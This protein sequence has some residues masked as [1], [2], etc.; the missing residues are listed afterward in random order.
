[1]H[2]TDRSFLRN[3]A[4]RQPDK[5]AARQA[6]HARYKQNPEPWFSWVFD[7]LDL[8]AGLRILEVGCGPADLWLH[9][10][11]RLP[12]GLSITLADLSHGM[13]AQSAAALPAE[14]GAARFSFLAADVQRLPFPDAH[15]D[16]V[17]ANHMLYHVPDLQAGL[18]EIRRVLVPGGRLCASANGRGHMIEI[19]ELAGQRLGE[20]VMED[21]VERFGL[22]VAPSVLSPSFA[23]IEVE[24]YPDAMWV[25]EAEPLVAYVASMFHTGET[26]PDLDAVRAQVEARIQSEGG[27]RVTKSSGIVR[28]VR[29]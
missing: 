13:A 4:Y 21:M 25:T 12:P 20:T 15:F 11:D 19:S 6:L 2:W 7:R 17:V 3:E 16:L 22:E 1:M 9:N 18:R 23:D 5:L 8:H 14:P 10:L 24:P 26:H 29:L 28:A 27:Y